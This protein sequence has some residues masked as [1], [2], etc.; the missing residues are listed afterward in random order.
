M[1]EVKEEP[2][3]QRIMADEAKLARQAIA[4]LGGGVGTSGSQNAVASGSGT[5]NGQA[6]SAGAQ[7]GAASLSDT[8]PSKGTTVL[9]PHRT[10]FSTAD[11]FFAECSTRLHSQYGY[12]ANPSKRK[13]DKVT[14]VR[15]EQGV[16]LGPL[17][18]RFD[19]TSPAVHLDD[20]S[21]GVSSSFDRSGIVVV[22]WAAA[23][24]AGGCF[25]LVSGAFSRN[26]FYSCGIL[27]PGNR[28]SRA[29][30]TCIEFVLSA[31]SFGC[32][33][34]R[35]DTPA[36]LSGYDCAVKADGSSSGSGDDAAA[37][38]SA[39][40]R[41]VQAA[42]SVFRKKKRTTK[43]TRVAKSSAIVLSSDDD[44]SREDDDGEYRS[45]A[46]EHASA[47]SGD[48]S[49]GES[50]PA[51]RKRSSR[52]VHVPGLPSV[53]DSFAS[54]TEAFKAY[55]KATVPVYGISVT[56]CAVS[57]TVTQI[58]CNRHHSH[59]SEHPGGVCSW[60]AVLKL[61]PKT[62]RWRIDAV[63]SHFKHSHG[64]CEEILRDPSFRPTVRN[65]DAREALGMPS[66]DASVSAKEQNMGEMRRCRA[67]TKDKDE[68]RAGT[69][70]SKGKER[71]RDVSPPSKKRRLPEEAT[72]EPPP[73]AAN[74]LPPPS[75]DANRQPQAGPSMYHTVHAHQPTTFTQAPQYPRPTAAPQ[76]AAYYVPSLSLLPTSDISAFLHG[77]HPS[78]ESLTPHFIAAGL[79][80]IDALA[81]LTHWTPS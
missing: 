28:A 14:L 66:L 69:S 42:P 77:L 2:E 54:T 48:E 80:T 79:T 70:K 19:D 39:L 60:Q 34:S 23:T 36:S 63:K 13:D 38:S 45:S 58:K 49:G 35:Y 27:A 53:N 68:R 74:T 29:N 21:S 43:R 71:A 76:P 6:S 5:Q 25:D 61:N 24:R 30:G 52:D 40:C 64:P 73:P 20:A 51:A 67:R 47:T 31:A 44:E 32:A 4:A 72:Q 55:V 33:T 3:S 16:Y 41:F 15:A 78:L 11:E 57:S 7:A 8:K 18:S 59:Y 9:F 65:P 37:F 1:S 12:P 17:A 62:R 50:E 10:S 46:L 56:K 22:H 81:S 26:K 75:E